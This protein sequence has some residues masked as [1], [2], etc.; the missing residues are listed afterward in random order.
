[1]GASALPKV[2]SGTLSAPAQEKDYVSQD[3]GN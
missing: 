3:S 2:T 1:M